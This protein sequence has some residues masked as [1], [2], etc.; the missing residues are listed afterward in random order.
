ALTQ[1]VAQHGHA[2]VP[3]S[4]ITDDGH[5]LGAWVTDQRRDQR[6]NRLDPARAARLQTLPGWDWSGN[7][8]HEEWLEQRWERG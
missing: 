2:R 1:F 3:G 8:G 6:K 4:H 5:R 7:A